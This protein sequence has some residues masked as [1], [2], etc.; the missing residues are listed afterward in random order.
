MQ[1]DAT[2]MCDTHPQKEHLLQARSTSWHLGFLRILSS[3]ICQI[4]TFLSRFYLS[5]QWGPSDWW[6]LLLIFLTEENGCS[7]LCDSLEVLR[8]TVMLP[9]SY[10]QSSPGPAPAAQERGELAKRV[11]SD[12]IL[13]RLTEK[14]LEGLIYYTSH[15]LLSPSRTCARSLLGQPHIHTDAS[16]LYT[17]GTS[18]L[19]L[20]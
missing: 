17:L 19:I 20:V 5:P 9:L 18:M 12:Y 3:L 15:I 8:G 7:P 13:V 14:V 11:P 10:L 2:W 16:I 1:N 6:L 4:W